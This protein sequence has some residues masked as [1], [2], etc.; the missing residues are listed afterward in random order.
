M[1]VAPKNGHTINIYHPS[2]TLLT[3]HITSLILFT[4]TCTYVKTGLGISGKK[5]SKMVG[6]YTQVENDDYKH[7]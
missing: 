2:F 5:I 7:E 6:Q 3:P 4:N 1:A